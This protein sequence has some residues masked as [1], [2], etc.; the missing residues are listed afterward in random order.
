MNAFRNLKIGTK[1]LIGYALVLLLLVVVG[2]LSLTR[3]NEIDAK[4][5]NI[6]D[7]LSVD[8]NLAHQIVEQVYRIRLFA[9]RYIAI[10]TRPTTNK[11]RRICRS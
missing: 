4:F 8:E 6:T 9:N 11:L 1:I 5:V 3:L 7:N 10:A 2:G